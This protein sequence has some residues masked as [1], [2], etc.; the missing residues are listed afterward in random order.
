[1][2][3]G[4]FF[5]HRI[6]R[7]VALRQRRPRFDL[8]FVVRTILAERY[9]RLQRMKFDLVYHRPH[10]RNLPQL[11]EMMDLE[12][13]DTDRMNL[14]LLVDFL[15]RFPG[16]GIVSAYGPMHEVQIDKIE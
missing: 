4:N 14:A 11:F 5:E 7:Q 1:M 12:I 15:E 8:N 16:L 13:A 9:R 2:S 3:V 6:L 10:G